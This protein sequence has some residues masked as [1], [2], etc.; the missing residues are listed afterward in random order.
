[1]EKEIRLN[2][3]DLIFIESIDDIEINAPYIV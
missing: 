3:G 2:E 1:M